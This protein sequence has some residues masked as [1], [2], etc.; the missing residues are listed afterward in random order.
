MIL[1]Q[2][3]VSSIISNGLKA[4]LV[5]NVVVLIIFMMRKIDV[6]SVLIVDIKKIYWHILFYQNVLIILILLS[7]DFIYVLQASVE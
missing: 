3:S 6:S 2:E 1:L 4:L 7:W 5:K